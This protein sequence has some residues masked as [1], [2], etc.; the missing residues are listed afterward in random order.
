LK[1]LP[2]FFQ[3]TFLNRIPVKCPVP[4]TQKL[5][6]Y[7]RELPSTYLPLLELTTIDNDRC[8][9]TRQGSCGRAVSTA[10]DG[11][12]YQHAWATSCA[13]DRPEQKSWL[14]STAITSQP[15]SRRHIP[16]RWSTETAFTVAADHPDAVLKTQY[17]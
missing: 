6:S 7:V 8:R 5:G 16:S 9:R 14:R 17:L 13:V 4:K 10:V 3:D 15:G 11:L 12:C 1:V 2:G